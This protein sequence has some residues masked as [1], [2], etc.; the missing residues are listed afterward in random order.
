MKERVREKP[1]AEQTKQL[2]LSLLSRVV[3]ISQEVV[4]SFVKKKKNKKT[5][6]KCGEGTREYSLVK[7]TILVTSEFQNN[8]NGP[9]SNGYELLFLKGKFSIL[10]G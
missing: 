9:G 5:E 6:T 8:C 7:F 2:M 10:M 4:A 1:K 3:S